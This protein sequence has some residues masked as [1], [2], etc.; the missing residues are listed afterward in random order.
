MN[1][2]L[3]SVLKQSVFKN[4][5]RAFTRSLAVAMINGVTAMC[6]LNITCFGTAFILHASVHLLLI[7]NS[8][9]TQFPS[10]K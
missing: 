10:T 9:S 6:V 3:K 4:S 2:H 8:V 5:I 7:N 1:I